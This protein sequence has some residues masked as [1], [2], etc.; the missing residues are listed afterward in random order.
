MRDLQL[1]DQGRGISHNIVLMK[2][3]NKLGK[4]QLKL[5]NVKEI[6]CELIPCEDDGKVDVV[7][8]VHDANIFINSKPVG[9]N[10]MELKVGDTFGI[11]SEKTLDEYRNL[12]GEEWYNIAMYTLE[13]LICEDGGQ[14]TDDEE[15]NECLSVGTEKCLEDDFEQCEMINLDD[16]DIDELKSNGTV[17][18]DPKPGPSMEPSLLVSFHDGVSVSK[19]DSKGDSSSVRPVTVSGEVMSLTGAELGDDFELPEL[20]RPRLEI[21][22]RHSDDDESNFDPNY[23]G[24]SEEEEIIPQIINDEDII[25]LSSSESTSDSSEEWDSTSGS[26]I[27]E[28]DSNESGFSEFSDHTATTSSSDSDSPQGVVFAKIIHNPLNPTFQRPEHPD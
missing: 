14:I 18:I 15:L 10:N 22:E 2:G 26:E 20:K 27:S 12:G 1:V 8:F 4:K 11:G 25:V 7:N 24:D 16:E 6:I 3:A 28:T 21:V 13:E 19:C 17:I 5:K 23:N 9:E